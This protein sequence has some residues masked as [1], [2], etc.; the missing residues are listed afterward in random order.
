[1]KQTKNQKSHIFLAP[2]VAEDKASQER[3]A[4]I[5]FEYVQQQFRNKLNSQG[6]LEVYIFT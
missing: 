4:I 5:S 1:M 6:D 2:K 3:C